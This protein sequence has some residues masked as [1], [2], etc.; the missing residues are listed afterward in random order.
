MA[1]LRFENDWSTKKTITSIC[2]FFVHFIVLLGIMAVLL[3]GKQLSNFT[4]HMR[5]FGAS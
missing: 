3:L 1:I 2:L 5:E 4:E